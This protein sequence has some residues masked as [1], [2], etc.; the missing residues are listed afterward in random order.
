MNISPTQDGEFAAAI[1]R[2][3]ER[4]KPKYVIET[5]TCTG[6]GTTRILFESLYSLGEA[7]DWTLVTIEVARK[8]FMK[9][10]ARYERTPEVVCLHGLSIPEELLPTREQVKALVIDEQIPG[11]YYDH[12]PNVRVDMYLSE[13]ASEGPD[14]LLRVACAAFECKPDLVL[15]DSAGHLGFIEFEYLMSLVKGTF[16][17][18]VDDR[19]HVKHHRTWKQIQHSSGWEII[20]QGPERFGWGIARCLSLGRVLYPETQFIGP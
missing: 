19:M 17:L 14:A 11:I 20:E 7:H 6:E 5:G 18:I 2:T 3:V 12:D 4:C 15:L 10:A 13:Q 8:L 16:V 9:A 1:R